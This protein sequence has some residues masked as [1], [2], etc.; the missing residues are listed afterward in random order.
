[1]Q[2]EM[3]FLLIDDQEEINLLMEKILSPY[4]TCVV[5]DNGL[6][7]IE[8]F[9]RAIDDEDP[10]TAVFL[11]IMMPGMDGHEVATAL[12]EVE[13]RKA[14]A[15]VP[16]KLLMITA[17]NDPGN[18]CKSFFRGGKADAYITKP[19][20]K[21]NLLDELRILEILPE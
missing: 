13:S 4:G 5:A 3:R 20:R 9:T 14:P 8:I 2:G 16:V 17:L 10:F 18:V 15:P 19:I 1:M 11:D 21:D 12:R 6:S 7:A